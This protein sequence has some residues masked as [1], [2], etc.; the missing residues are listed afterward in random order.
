[1]LS[2]S[3]YFKW[4][5]ERRSVLISDL[6]LSTLQVTLVLW[7]IVHCTSH[8]GWNAGVH[9][10]HLK[11]TCNTD[12]YTNNTSEWIKERWDRI[13]RWLRPE[14]ASDQM[15]RYVLEHSRRKSACRRPFAE[16]DP[17]FFNTIHAVWSILTLRGLRTREHG[18]EKCCLQCLLLQALEGYICLSKAVAQWVRTLEPDGVGLSLGFTSYQLN[19]LQ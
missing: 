15:W 18:I 9:S 2:L 7:L 1:M 8:Y 10:R 11:L 14:F 4:D 12:A 3:R 5:L 17:V 16:R 13:K 19:G 6:M